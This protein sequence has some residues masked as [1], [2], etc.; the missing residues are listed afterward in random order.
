MKESFTGFCEVAQRLAERLGFGEKIGAALGQVFE[1]WDGK[2]SPAGQRREDRTSMRIVALAQ[3]AITIRRLEGP[4][5]LLKMAREH[6]GTLYD[7]HMVECFCPRASQLLL[8]LEEEPTWEAVL[9]LEAG[10]ARSALAG[11]QFD[12]GLPRDRRFRGSQV[13]G[14]HVSAIRS[15]WPNSRLKPPVTV[16]CPHPIRS[17]SSGRAL[18]HDLGRVGISAG[19]WGKPGPLSEEGVGT[20]APAP[21]LYGARAG[22]AW[23]AGSP[24]STGGPSS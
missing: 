12:T 9:A 10:C 2:A 14:V 24:G 19:I 16:D 4:R 15:E 21:V 8:G 3:D 22:P 6:K 23:S 7:P 17:C 11:E 18:L 5:Q 20:G 1:P 13:A